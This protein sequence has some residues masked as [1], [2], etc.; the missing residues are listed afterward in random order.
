MNPGFIPVIFYQNNEWK[1]VSCLNSCY[2]KKPSHYIYAVLSNH[3]YNEKANDGEIVQLTSDKLDKDHELP[4][5]LLLKTFEENKSGFYAR[6]YINRNTKQVVLA[7]RGTK[8]RGDVWEDGEGVLFNNIT[9]RQATISL[10]LDHLFDLAK[11]EGLQPSCTGHSLGAWHACIAALIARLDYPNQPNLPVVIFDSPGASDK[12]KEMLPRYKKVNLNE[13]DI[14][15]YLSSPNWVNCAN[16]QIGTIY[17][18]IYEPKIYR[19]NLFEKINNLRAALE[20]QR[21][22]LNEQKLK[23]PSKLIVEHWTILNAIDETANFISKIMHN[24]ASHNMD[25]ILNQFDKKSGKA[26]N[27]LQ[28]EDWPLL[29]HNKKLSGHHPML[30][31]DFLNESL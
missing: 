3:V 13:L 24:K 21:R 16:P 2:H 26:H 23:L 17:R 19:K 4:D 15:T 11:K 31:T 12:L 20:K 28:V 9:E 6:Y 22:D 10:A 29:D 25:G 30:L 5:W 14:I 27:Y 18:L 1:K 8:N 7:F